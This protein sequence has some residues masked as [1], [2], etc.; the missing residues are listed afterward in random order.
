MVGN[1]SP[2]PPGAGTPK[3][4][5][6]AIFGAVLVA[7]FAVSM[8]ML[9][10]DKNLQTNFGAQSPYYLHWYGVL[11]MGVLDLIVGL[12]IIAAS[13]PSILSKIGPTTRRRVVVGGLAWT[14]LALVAVLGIVATYA[15]VGFPSAGEFARYLFGVSAYPGALSYIPG[16][17]DLLVAM[18]L[19]A[20][21]VGALAAMRPA[22]DRANASGGTR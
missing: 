16:L 1:D 10:T 20:A 22:L 17:Y 12:A 9:A 2:P 18:Y 6:G 5:R 11:A 15:Q 19:V 14:I 8:V 4:R 21:A 3:N 7:T 13:T